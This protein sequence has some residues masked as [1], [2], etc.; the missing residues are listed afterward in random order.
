MWNVQLR[1]FLGIDLKDNLVGLGYTLR[2]L[3]PIVIDS[4][5]YKSAV[6]PKSDTGA[7]L[8]TDAAD[9]KASLLVD[10]QK[11]LKGTDKGAVSAEAT[12][13]LNSTIIAE[14]K[15][16]AHQQNIDD[17]LNEELGLATAEVEVKRMNALRAE[18]G[19]PQFGLTSSSWDL[20]VTSALNMEYIFDTL[21][22]DVPDSLTS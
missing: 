21:R 5:R 1:N 8:S 20:I 18:Y 19:P 13:L 7:V 22:I 14:D 12:S 15:S 10:K 2:R 3:C 17:F 11:A 9:K 16:K 6:K 4:D